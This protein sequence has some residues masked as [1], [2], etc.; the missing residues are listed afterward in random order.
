MMLPFAT[1]Q[2]PDGWV[3]WAAIVGVVAGILGIFAAVVKAAQWLDER[4]VEQIQSA[5]SKITETNGGHSLRD[6]VKEAVSV[7]KSNSR[8]IAGLR[9]EFA[10]HV[11]AGAAIIAASDHSRKRFDQHMA[12]HKARGW[13]ETGAAQ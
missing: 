1:M 7:S 5:V 8:A 11:D 3:H 9:R 10:E 6:D 12:D 13:R 4:N 2:P